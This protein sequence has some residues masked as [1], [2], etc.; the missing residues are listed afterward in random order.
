MDSTRL[1]TTVEKQYLV[2]YLALIAEREVDTVDPWREVIGQE[3]IKRCLMI[4][5]VSQRLVVLCGTGHNG[6]RLLMAGAA[7][8]GVPTLFLTPCPCGYFNDPHEAC[9][10]SAAKIERH[11]R[12]WAKS[13]PCPGPCMW[14]VVPP[15]PQREIVRH[16]KGERSGSGLDGIL[17]RVETARGR[18]V[19]CVLSTETEAL[20]LSAIA[21]LNLSADTVEYLLDVAVDIAKFDGD[22]SLGIMHLSEAIQYRYTR[23]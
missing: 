7:K 14:A 16:A 23:P 9:K 6:E 2:A 4:A 3:H 21:S 1:I 15:V 13:C 19:C 11:Q 12:A 8:L 18:T 22:E 10:C 20:L 5:A 17:Q